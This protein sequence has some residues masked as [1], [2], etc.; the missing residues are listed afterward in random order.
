MPIRNSLLRA[1]YYTSEEELFYDKHSTFY[2]RL[3]KEYDGTLFGSGG[4]SFAYSSLM[5]IPESIP[6]LLKECTYSLNLYLNDC[7]ISVALTDSPHRIEHLVAL[8]ILKIFAMAVHSLTCL[9]SF[10]IH[11]LVRLPQINHCIDGIKQISSDLNHPRLNYKYPIYNA[12]RYV[13]NSFSPMEQEQI[14]LYQNLIGD[15]IG[16]LDIELQRLSQ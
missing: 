16:T 15:P 13:N 12:W 10:C 5:L 4:N 6:L 7:I 1:L 2:T 9:L 14:N 11:C 3:K 8:T